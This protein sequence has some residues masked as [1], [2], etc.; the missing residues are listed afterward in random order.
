MQ[1]S[2]VVPTYNRAGLLARC[3]AALR[4]QTLPAETFEVIVVDDGSSD[5]T[6][7]LL[8]RETSPAWNLRVVRQDN[9]GPSAA[10]NSGVA[11]ARAPIIAFTDDDCLPDPR[12]L[13]RIVRNFR[14][15][16]E[17]VGLGGRTI[18]IPEELTPLSHWV[19]DDLPYSFPSCNLACSRE[20]LQQVGG[21]DERLYPNED[22]DITFALQGVGPMHYDP[23]MIVIHPPRPCGF[24]ELVRGMRRW[25]TEFLLQHKH[26]R[27]YAASVHRS[28][29]RVIYYHQM[30]VQAA[31]RLWRFRRLA[32]R[33]PLA[34][35]E[36]IGLLLAQRA[37][38]IAL[39]P[40]FLRT[41]RKWAAA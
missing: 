23:E 30:F 31:L 37:Y 21:F 3:L 5:G 14:E 10:R 18:T 13:E 1:V 4:S 7:E 35:L 2:V 17:L 8:A 41:R 25:D 19:E 15:R 29:W 6:G 22:W 26:P 24:W 40:H 12:W 20:A 33:K 32:L 39:F 28:P 16:P 27:E 34:Y 38:L 11:A 36:L 9:R